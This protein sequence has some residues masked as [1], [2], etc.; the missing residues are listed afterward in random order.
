MP[1]R[2][3]GTVYATQ[4]WKKLC[5]QIKERDGYRCRECGMPGRQ[6]GGVRVLTV[7]HINAVRVAPHLALA[8]MNL[9][10]LCNKC[11]GKQ[12]GGRRYASRR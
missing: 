11:H 5:V 1:V 6:I 2:K 12:D 10:T 7:Q 9:I 3:A 8:P 4:A